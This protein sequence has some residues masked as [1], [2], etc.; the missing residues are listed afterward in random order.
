MVRGVVPLG[1]AS[2]VLV[3]YMLGRASLQ[4]CANREI[5][6]FKEFELSFAVVV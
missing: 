3:R 1:T 6:S 2:R 4:T 5:L